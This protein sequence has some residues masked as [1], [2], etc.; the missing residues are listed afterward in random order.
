MDD[1]GGIDP[2]EGFTNHYPIFK[3]AAFSTYPFPP[4]L[5]SFFSYFLVSF[6]ALGSTG[7]E[8]SPLS[9]SIHFLLIS[10]MTN[11]YSLLL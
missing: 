3:S 5:T 2:E 10:L 11:L 1:S 9:S 7:P 8:L 4:F 6:L